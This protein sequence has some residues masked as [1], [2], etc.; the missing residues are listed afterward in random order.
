MVYLKAP[1]WP[2][3]IGDGDKALELLQ[4][5]VRKGPDY[6]MNHVFYARALWEVEG[7]D[8]HGEIAANLEEALRLMNGERWRTVRERWMVEVTD[9]AREAHVDLAVR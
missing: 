6:P 8:A 7:E 9:V 4:E 1:P 2:G 5:A 3:G